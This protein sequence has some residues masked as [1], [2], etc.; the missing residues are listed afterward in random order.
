MLPEYW[1]LLL[2]Y[3]GRGVVNYYVVRVYFLSEV[4]FGRYV[5]GMYVVYM[6]YVGGMYESK[7]VR[8]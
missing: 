2:L 7:P 8:V 3:Y 6:W 1:Y 4:W 5:C